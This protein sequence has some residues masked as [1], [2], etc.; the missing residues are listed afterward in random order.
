MSGS[1]RV[2]ANGKGPQFEGWQRLEKEWSSSSSLIPWMNQHLPPLAITDPTFTFQLSTSLFDSNL[3]DRNDRG[4]VGDG[5]PYLYDAIASMGL[6][7]CAVAT[8]SSS[9]SSSSSSSSTPLDGKDIHAKAKQQSFIGVSGRIEY[10]EAGSRSAETG[11]IEMTNLRIKTEGG[12]STALV[13]F[14]S[15]GNWTFED[16][17]VWYAGNGTSPP[18]WRDPPSVDLHLIDEG[19]KVFMY[20]SFFSLGVF[21][22][23]F[24]L[25]LYLSHT[26]TLCSLVLSVS[27]S[28]VMV[29]VE[30]ALALCCAAWTV[31]FRNAPVVKA[32]QPT[33][34]LLVCV[35]AIVSTFVVLPLSPD[36]GSSTTNHNASCRLLVPLFTIG[37]C[38]TFASLFA[39]Q[40]RV[41]WVFR[42]AAKMK[43]AKA[44]T[45]LTKR[46]MLAVVLFVVIVD[47]ALLV[48]WDI[49]A[50]LSWK[51]MPLSFDE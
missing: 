43:R 25:S 37:F 38:V 27:C 6:A 11:R 4:D 30:S 18:P 23:F 31:Y 10:N 3:K 48:A 20:E 12:V 2:L 22:S 13:A 5:A 45:D 14:F 46:W 50:P 33:F 24:S 42:R 19:V 34:L 21:V 15:G 32:S 41:W 28:Y 16:V 51:V 39:K 8:T 35:G 1:L 40:F 7:A 44:G 49:S 9:P 36:Q 47:V 26:Y 17:D 29:G